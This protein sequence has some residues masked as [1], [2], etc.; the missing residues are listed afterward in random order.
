VFL[1][2]REAGEVR[3]GEEAS[4]MHEAAAIHVARLGDEAADHPALLV[5]AR[6]ERAGS[7]LE[8][9]VRPGFPARPGAG[10]DRFGYAHELGSGKGF[11]LCLAGGNALVMP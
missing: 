4:A 7:S 5:L 9:V 2:D 3:E 6:I 1:G 11:S 10:F 8:R